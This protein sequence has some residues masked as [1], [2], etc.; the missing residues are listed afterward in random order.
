[1][2]EFF[3]A[4]DSQTWEKPEVFAIAKALGV[5][6]GDAFLACLCLWDYFRRNSIDG[7]IEGIT[8][9]VIDRQVRMPGFADAACRY[10]WLEI[11]E[12]GCRQP[13]FAFHAHGSESIKAYRHRMRA[14][15]SRNKAELIEA[16]KVVDPKAAAKFAQSDFDDSGEAHGTVREKR[17]KSKEKEKVKQTG[18]DRTGGSA[19]ATQSQESQTTEPTSESL[20]CEA[21][22]KRV[23][24]ELSQMLRSSL[25]PDSDS[26]PRVPRQCWTAACGW[27]DEL[28]AQLRDAV[29]RK[30]A[31][32][33]FWT[34]WLRQLAAPDP[35]SGDRTV[36]NAVSA[37]ALAEWAATKPNLERRVGYFRSRLQ[38]GRLMAEAVS[39]LPD[40]AVA[41]ALMFVQSRLGIPQIKRPEP[42][43]QREAAAEKKPKAVDPALLEQTEFGKKVLQRRKLREASM[44][45]PATE[46]GS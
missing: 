40:K 2:S 41:Q 22:T 24:P 26:A 43:P 46:T 21:L 39:E 6:Q 15:K 44:A 14:Q 4:I 23:P 7:F 3:H 5:S 29:T 17:T 37:M 19:S 33:Q 12:S 11:T 32:E 1:M 30:A 16:L 20:V 25:A 27:S 31:R 8:A 45:D 42:S 34:W 10:H 28:L 18:P 35:A 36:A 38:T 13:G 9:E